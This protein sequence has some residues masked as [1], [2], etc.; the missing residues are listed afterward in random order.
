MREDGAK[1]NLIMLHLAA[2]E[3][4]GESGSQSFGKKDFRLSG[5]ISHGHDSNAGIRKNKMRKTE[6]KEIVFL[7]EEYFLPAPN[8]VDENLW[9]VGNSQFK[10]PP[11]FRPLFFNLPPK[12]NLGPSRF[13]GLSVRG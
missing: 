10:S 13:P 9:K 3:T 5:K 6:D 2:E 1:R 8:E 4:G 7:G 12:K 11:F